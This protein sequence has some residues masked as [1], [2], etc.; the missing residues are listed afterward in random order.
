V[1]SPAKT[2]RLDVEATTTPSVP[3]I[4]SC[5]VDQ[6]HRATGELKWAPKGIDETLEFTEAT[7]LTEDA[8]TRFGR[9]PCSILT[10]CLRKTPADARTWAEY[11]KRHGSRW[12]YTV[13]V[14]VA[15]EPDPIR[16]TFLQGRGS[17]AFRQCV[18]HGVTDLLRRQ[19]KVPESGA[20]S[21]FI[22]NAA[23]TVLQFD[24]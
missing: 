19:L 16:V 15:P 8:L 11:K 10:T 23:T 6:F 3:G 5:F 13:N 12:R 21:P 24:C 7:F 20:P 22:D 14:H 4:E 17:A 18:E 2:P 1:R 9:Y